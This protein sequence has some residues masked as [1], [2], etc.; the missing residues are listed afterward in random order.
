MTESYKTG[1]ALWKSAKWTSG[2][3]GQVASLLRV[4]KSM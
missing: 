2:G 1:S 4:S 3:A